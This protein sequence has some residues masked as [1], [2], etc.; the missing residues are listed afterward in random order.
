M[1]LRAQGTVKQLLNFDDN[2]GSPMHLNVFST[3]LAVSTTNGFVK[4]YDVAA[5]YAMP[6]PS[7]PACHQVHSTNAVQQHRARGP[8]AGK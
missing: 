1:C 8:L 2:E 3:F 7:P 6:S 4:L 5:R